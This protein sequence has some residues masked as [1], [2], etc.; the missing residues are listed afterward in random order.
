M[1][2]YGDDN[3]LIRDSDAD[4]PEEMMW[5]GRFI[6]AKR[7]GRWEYVGRARGI[8]AAAIIAIDEDDDGTRHVILVAQYR[9]PLGAF[10][11][12]IPAGLVGDDAGGENEDPTDAAA[13][14]LEEETGYAA[15][16]MEVLG[17]FFSSP[18]MVSESFTLLRASG[19][20]K[21]AEGGGVSGENIIVHRVALE[22]LS[23][24]V[25]AWRAEGHAVDVRIAMLLTP[26]YLG[27]HDYD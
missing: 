20:T 21:I 6:T 23:E 12:E 26:E 14:E 15:D 1:D 10:C 17:E 4:E 24:F 5:E 22:D 11:L 8:R 19:L 27:D 9:V 25:A 2:E 13:R 16:R 3:E 18:G 7:R